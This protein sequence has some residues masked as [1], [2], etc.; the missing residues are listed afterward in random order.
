MDQLTHRDSDRFRP[1]LT[2]IKSR[3]SS[4]SPASI[5]ATSSSPSP[6]QDSLTDLSILT[7]SSLQLILQV[8]GVYCTEKQAAQLFDLYD[9]EKK[10][11][12]TLH[13]LMCRAHNIAFKTRE[14][15]KEREKELSQER[16]KKKVK[17]RDTI[18]FD[19]HFLH[20]PEQTQ[21]NLHGKTLSV[22]TTQQQTHEASLGNEPPTSP[23]LTKPI[24]AIFRAFREKMRV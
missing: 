20:H 15:E 18:D 19:A 21:K 5:H 13:Q 6:F 14:K 11:E 16:A 9:F 17:R 2:F 7:R 24:S 12:I 4:S 8:L 3:L 10:G 22:D 23:G 1:L